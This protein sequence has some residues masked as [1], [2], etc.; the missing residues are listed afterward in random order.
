ME[1]SLFEYYIGEEKLFNQLEYLGGWVYYDKY[2]IDEVGLKGFL[3]GWERLKHI[4]FREAYFD[5]LTDLIIYTPAYIIR[6]REDSKEE[7]VFYCHIEKRKC[8]IYQVSHDLVNSPV[9]VFR[10]K[11]IKSCTKK[12]M[13]TYILSLSSGNVEIDIITY[14]DLMYIMGKISG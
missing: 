8:T 3:K 14:C 9:G 12:D 13:T 4:E 6:F 11:D 7:G 5:G 1:N 10:I 2:I